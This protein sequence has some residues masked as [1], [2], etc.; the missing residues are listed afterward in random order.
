LLEER[1]FINKQITENIK[2][3]CNNLKDSPAK[4]LSSVLE[5]SHRR[6]DL[7]KILI[8]LDDGSQYLSSD[9]DTVKEHTRLHFSKISSSSHDPPEQLW[10][11]WSHYYQPLNH[12]KSSWYNSILPPLQE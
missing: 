5:K 11:E 1:K 7:N 8:T 2:K 12:I 3:H 9:P 6:I 4:M 10:G